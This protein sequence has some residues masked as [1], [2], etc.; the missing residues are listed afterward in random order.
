MFRKQHSNHLTMQILCCLLMISAVKGNTILGETM[1][2]EVID[3]IMEYGSTDYSVSEAISVVSDSI[4]TVLS[5]ETQPEFSWPCNESHS[6]ALAA[7]S[8]SRAYTFS[9]DLEELQVFS[10]CGGTV[11]QISDSRIVISHGNGF[12]TVYEGCTDLYVQTLQKVRRGELIGS[13][14]SSGDDRPELGF[15]LLKEQQAV[16]IGEYI[17][18]D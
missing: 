14:R 18:A 6:L 8:S 7:D 5:A 1:V 15:Q 4:S 13:V 10:S 9:S 12:E 17:D 11:S 2:G 3:R 16:D